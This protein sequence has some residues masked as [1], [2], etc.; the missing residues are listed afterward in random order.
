MFL[1]F[2]HRK[3]T[4]NRLLETQCRVVGSDCDDECRILQVLNA[5]WDVCVSVVNENALPCHDRAGYNKIL[6]DAKPPTDP[7]GRHFSSFTYL[8]LN[9]HLMERHNFMEFEQFVKRMHGKPPDRQCFSLK[10]KISSY[11]RKVDLF[12][13]PWCYIIIPSHFYCF[14][15]L[16]RGS[17]PS[18]TT[19]LVLILYYC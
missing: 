11:E 13:L 18:L 16:C 3:S 9:P 14:R 12:Q 7:D 17:S 6:D 19:N 5:A 4:H 8:R 10:A 15:L 1:L 2:Q